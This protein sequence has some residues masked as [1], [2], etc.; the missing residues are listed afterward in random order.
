[1]GK[2]KI[3]GRILKQCSSKVLLAKLVTRDSWFFLSRFVVAIF[4]S[5]APVITQ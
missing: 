1:M 4:V 5:S 2:G 3:K